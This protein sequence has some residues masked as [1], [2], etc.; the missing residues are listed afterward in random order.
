MSESSKTTTAT[1]EEDTATMQDMKKVLYDTKVM[2]N[3]VQKSAWKMTLETFGMAEGKT[4]DSD[5]M[6]TDMNEALQKL[7]AMIPEN[8]EKF[9]FPVTPFQE[10]D[11]TLDQMLQAFIVWSNKVEDGDGE[12]VYNVDK[13]FRRLEA[14]ASWMYEH[15]A[16]LEAPLTPESM[17]APA[18]AWGMKVTYSEKAKVTVWWFDMAAL[19]LK[20]IKEE[21]EIKD[22]LRLFVWFS[23][24]MVMDPSCQENGMILVESLAKKGMWESMTMVPMDLGAQ[25]DRLTIGSLPLKMK[26]LYMFYGARWIHF[27]LALIKPFMSQKMRSRMIIIPDADDPIKLIT[28]EF[29]KECIPKDFANLNGLAKKDLI[30]GKY[31]KSQIDDPEGETEC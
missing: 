9:K 14:Y 17:L 21:L 31:L 15:R 26:K 18:L 22:S 2:D 24:I 28:E 7:K 11:F 23:H 3:G 10:L 20:A 25:L 12:P 5:A 30:F 29:G 27:F 6:V 19:N 8:D 13:A 4:S 16:D 1:G